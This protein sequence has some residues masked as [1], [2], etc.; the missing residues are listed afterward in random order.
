MSGRIMRTRNGFSLVEAAIVLAVVGLVIGGIWAVSAQIQY[1]RKL[2][3]TEQGLYY[4][5]NQI[6]TLITSKQAVEA[7][8]NGANCNLQNVLTSLQTPPGW[9]LKPGERP[10]DPFN[11]MIYS[12][13]SQSNPATGRIGGL[14]TLGYSWQTI[15][16]RYVC[17]RI[18]Y[19]M[20]TK[21]GRSYLPHG[22]TPGCSQYNHDP[23]GAS[24]DFY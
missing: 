3:E 14:F 8:C 1:S 21:I 12:E 20:V 4:Y 11:N 7:G 2:T 24:V 16:D 15:S 19:F 17:A 22:A 6:G 10:R 5:A 23:S 9:T 18:K 13:L